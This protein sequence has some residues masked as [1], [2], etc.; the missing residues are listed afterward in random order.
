MD[1]LTAEQMRGLIYLQVRLVLSPDSSRLRRVKKRQVQRLHTPIADRSLYF[2]Q[3][4]ISG[5]ATIF[6]TR[7]QGFSW[8]VRIILSET[9]FFVPRKEN[10]VCL[11]PRREQQI[12]TT[13]ESAN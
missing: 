5:L 11:V 2:S 13:A 1:Q 12:G 6:V 10:S 7:S 4:S 9:I 3:V 8:M